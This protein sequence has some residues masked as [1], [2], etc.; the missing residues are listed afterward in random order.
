[1]SPRTSLD[2]EK[3]TPVKGVLK[4]SS[5]GSGTPALKK[6]KGKDSKGMS[7]ASTP[8]PSVNGTSSKGSRK[9]AADFF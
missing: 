4:Y 5:S 7:K 8:S 3:A 2:G 9:R 6:S 1:M